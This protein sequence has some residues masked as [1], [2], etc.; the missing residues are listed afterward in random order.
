[1]TVTVG[2]NQASDAIRRPEDPHRHFIA[3]SRADHLLA[4]TQLLAF[5]RGARPD[6]KQSQINP[7]PRR[8]T[9]DGEY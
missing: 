5:V 3:Q 1:M 8:T 6:A 7:A 9:I 2:L 4:L